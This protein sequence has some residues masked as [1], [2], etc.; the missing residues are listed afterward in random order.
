[1]KTEYIYAEV[2]IEL[3]DDQIFVGCGVEHWVRGSW[4]GK[5]S[6]QVISGRVIEVC[7]IASIENGASLAFEASFRKKVV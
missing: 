2:F 5:G 4:H 7:A 1:M 3:C 6:E